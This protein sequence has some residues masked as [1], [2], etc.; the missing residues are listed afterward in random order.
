MQKSGY[1][2]DSKWYGVPVIFELD[3]DENIK[4]ID[5]PSMGANEDKYT[6]QPVKNATASTDAQKMA[7]NN[8][9]Y[10][11]TTS[12]F[13]SMFPLASTCNVI[14]LPSD[15]DDLNDASKYKT[16]KSFVNEKKY[17]VQMF[18][19]D[20]DVYTSNYVL[21]A[22]GAQGKKSTT[23]KTSIVGAM[24][25]DNGS[26]Y[27]SSDNPSTKYVSLFVVKEAFNALNDDD[28]KTLMITGI[29]NGAEVTYTL[30]PE[31]FESNAVVEM[32][33]NYGAK[34]TDEGGSRTKN[35]PVI[36]GDVLRIIQHKDTKY[37][38]A[39]TP[40]FFIE[41]KAFAAN[42][43]GGSLDGKHSYTVDISAVKEI[44]G[45]NAVMS[46]FALP[47]SSGEY[48]Y[49][50]VMNGKMLGSNGDLTWDADNKVYEGLYRGAFN[51]GSA[52]TTVYDAAKGDGK[53]VSTGTMNDIVTIDD[54]AANENPSIVIV[55][56]QSGSAKEMHIINL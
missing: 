7:I 51:V 14:Q 45:S 20:P 56:Y 22:D 5:T 53:K 39:L 25:D 29:E 27:S 13:T 55:R 6:L 36:E 32:F 2:N 18:T 31:L 34:F 38:I 19:T 48:K 49:Q 9:Q 11:S 1:Y 50:V 47:A 40:I 37:V 52:K 3:D 43:D 21:V 24:T 12:A 17:F 16:S 42:T 41:E 15:Y 4:Y 26:K 54:A 35:M 8:L 33:K 10:S 23:F 28:E 46:Y 44:N 30:D